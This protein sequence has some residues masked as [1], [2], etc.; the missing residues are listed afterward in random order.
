MKIVVSDNYAGF[1]SQV[2]HSCEDLVD[3]FADNRT[4]VNFV[5]FVENNPKLKGDLCIVEIPDNATDWLIAEHDNHYEAVF[6]VV[7]GKIRIITP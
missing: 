6:Y 4:D 5:N 2:H 3:G 7:N 1:G